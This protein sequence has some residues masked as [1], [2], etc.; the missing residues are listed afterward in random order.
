MCECC[1]T[2]LCNKQ[3]QWTYHTKYENIKMKRGFENDEENEEER[4]K[5]Q[6]LVI[7]PFEQAYSNYITAVEEEKRLIK[8][9]SIAGGLRKELEDIRHT[10]NNTR[11]ELEKQNVQ[12]RSEYVK[13]ILINLNSTK[14]WQSYIDT[15]TIDT[16]H[17]SMG[18]DTYFSRNTP[19]ITINDAVRVNVINPAYTDKI[20]IRYQNKDFWIEISDPEVVKFDKR[21]KTMAKKLQKYSLFLV[22]LLR[23][24]KFEQ[25]MNFATFLQF[26]NEQLR[27]NPRYLINK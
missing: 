5:K 16:S 9:N 27:E 1:T 19:T 14:K 8:S 10:L 22:W 12:K 13:N 4:K 21:L 25:D 17:W 3:C 15:L 24:V 18:Y 26:L 6:V 23:D 20:P 11:L 7:D 2:P